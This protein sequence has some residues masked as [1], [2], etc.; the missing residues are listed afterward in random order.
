[1]PKT[2]CPAGA[3]TALADTGGDMLIE[4]RDDIYVCTDG[5]DPADP[6]ECT[7]LK[8]GQRMVVKA[9]IAVTVQPQPNRSSARVISQ[10]I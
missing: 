9:G 2:I 4:A 10:L 1:M 7:G 3:W 6:E 8:G 5:S